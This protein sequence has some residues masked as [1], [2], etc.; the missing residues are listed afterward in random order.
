MSTVLILMTFA[1]RGKK[2]KAPTVEVPETTGATVST[3][4]I[5]A[6]VLTDRI[7]GYICLQVRENEVPGCP[8]PFG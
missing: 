4:S 6:N 2:V 3:E 7:E 8:D 1:S 5:M